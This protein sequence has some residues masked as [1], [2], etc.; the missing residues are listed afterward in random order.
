MIFPAKC[1]GCLDPQGKLMWILPSP[2]AEAIIG[3][4]AASG[5][6]ES[7]TTPEPDAG[8][9]LKFTGDD[10]H[11]WRILNGNWNEHPLHVC[12]VQAGYVVV[13]R[14]VDKDCGMHSWGKI[15]RDK[16]KAA[17][18][19]PPDK[20]KTI[21]LKR[22]PTTV[23][24]GMPLDLDADIRRMVSEARD[25]VDS[26]TAEVHEDLR[27]MVEETRDMYRDAGGVRVRYGRVPAK[28]LQPI[29]NILDT[30]AHVDGCWCPACIAAR[31][32]A[33][34][35]KALFK[36]KDKEDAQKGRTQ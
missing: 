7:V 32:V 8:P 9:G 11:T 28:D 10:N 17:E 22:P 34:M 25:L 20:P 2:N 16:A 4:M 31:V 23:P 15:Q 18:P 26:T 21:R 35:K 3:E 27:K 12:R 29:P 6:F 33:C 1:L 5:L 19:P 14:M 36:D 13:M 24:S 30:K